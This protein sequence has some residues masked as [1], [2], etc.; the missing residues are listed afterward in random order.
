MLEQ[1]DNQPQMNPSGDLEK[2]AN[3]PYYSQGE[4][5]LRNKPRCCWITTFGL[6]RNLSSLIQ[7]YKGKPEVRA[8]LTYAGQDISHW[9]DESTGDIRHHIHPETGVRVPY[10]PFG[11]IPHVDTP[12]PSYKWKGLHVIPWWKD[13]RNIVGNL[14]KKQRPINIVNM[15]NKERTYLLVCCEDTMTQIQERYSKFNTNT[16]QY[17][18]KYNGQILDMEKTLDGNGIVDLTDTFEALFIPQDYHIP[19]ILIYFT[20]EIA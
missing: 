20:D 3:L 12:L 13:E 7:Q 11:K 19:S 6:V 17:V 5:A 15:L 2:F 4:V 1:L 18:W 16:Q 8:L 10:T 14:T 9:F